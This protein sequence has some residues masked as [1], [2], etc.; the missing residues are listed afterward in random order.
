[1]RRAQSSRRF[2]SNIE[3]HVRCRHSCLGG[4]CS[5][6]SVD[7]ESFEPVSKPSYLLEAIQRGQ[8]LGSAIS[9]T[10]STTYRGH[11]HESRAKM[12]RMRR[13]RPLCL[14][15][16]RARDG[17]RRVRG[18][19]VISSVHT[20]RHICRRVDL[21]LRGA[22]ATRS[23]ARASRDAWERWS[24]NETV[25]SGMSSRRVRSLHFRSGRPDRTIDQGV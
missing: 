15:P 6:A 16:P 1:M 21:L 3:L 25:L 7:G 24:G 13:L 2:S 8:L 18:R 4:M 20:S 12:L 19:P 23:I 22:H 14:A 17:D 9:P 5:D 11:A 10:V